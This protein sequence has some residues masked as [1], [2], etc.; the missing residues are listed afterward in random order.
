[1]G[2]EAVLAAVHGL[3]RVAGVGVDGGDDPVRGDPLRD[4]ACQ[5]V[6]VSGSV[7]S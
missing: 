4:G 7:S 2:F 3:V 6:C 1:V 5:M